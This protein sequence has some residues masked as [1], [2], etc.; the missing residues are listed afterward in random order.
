MMITSFRAVTIGLLLA[1]AVPVFAQSAAPAAPS[2]PAASA[3]S[4]RAAKHAGP[5]GRH[6]GMRGGM[7][8]GLSDAGRAMMRDATKAGDPRADH[9]AVK[10][11]RDR[12]LV[13]L[14]ADRLDTAALKRAM[15]EERKAVQTGHDRRQAAMLTGFSKLTLEDRK[16]F[17]ANARG[18]RARMEARV[19]KGYGRRDGGGRGGEMPP[20]P[21]M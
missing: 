3:P 14:E 6:H 8:A 5:D 12:M 20:Q 2:A 19:G 21:M 10:A 16:A 7:F 1:G 11:A 15:E 9:E 13:V 4:A 18:M 17:V